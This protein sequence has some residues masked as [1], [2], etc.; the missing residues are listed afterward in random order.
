MGAKS[1]TNVQYISGVYTVSKCF[2]CFML[3]PP[4]SWVTE[5]LQPSGAALYNS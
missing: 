2:H 1:Q 5:T 4:I 3:L